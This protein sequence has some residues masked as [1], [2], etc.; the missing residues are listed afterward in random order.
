VR[1]RVLESVIRNGTVTIS[2]VIGDIGKFVPLR[3]RAAAGRRDRRRLSGGTCRVS[4]PDRGLRRLVATALHGLAMIGCIKHIAKGVYGRT[5]ATVQPP[6]KPLRQLIREF[7]AK[8]GESTVSQVLVGVASTIPIAQAAR[9]GQRN[10]RR[11]RHGDLIESGKRLMVGDILVQLAKIG[12]IRRV[13]VGV[14]APAL[15]LVRPDKSA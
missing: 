2:Q 3:A 14:Y 10:L 15:R 7:I 5:S 1:Q 6:K 12:V 9:N 4:I 11:H 13:R 8:Y